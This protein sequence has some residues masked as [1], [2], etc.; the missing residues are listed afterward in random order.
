M[1]QRIVGFHQDDEGHW[2]AELECSH[3]QHLRHHP[4]WQNRPWVID[5]HQRQRFLGNKLDCKL[6]EQGEETQMATIRWIEDGVQADGVVEREFV[7]ERNGQIIPGVFWRPAD[8][9]SPQPLVLMGHGGSGHKRNDRMQMLGRLFSTGYGCCAA[10]IDGPV[11]GARGTVT[12]PNDPAFREM[13]RRDNPV[14]GMIDDWTA[15][16]DVLSQLEIVDHTRIG[17]WGVSMGTM[18][19]L[20]YVASDERVRV[21]VLGKAGTTGSS[22]RRSGI[23]TYFKTYA[24][25]VKVP[26]LFTIQ[27]DD[28]RFD[29]DGQLDLFDQ[30]GSQDKRLH[31]YPGL[32]IANGPEAFE[33]QAAF[34]KRYL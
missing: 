23:D 18:F 31:A 19:G 5:P 25:Q 12:D 9:S 22:V 32:H 24:P 1:Q 13:W 7:V 8:L 30:L 28:E 34:L 16:L 11:H 20:P 4:P 33:V 2:V 6:C 14:Q 29:R 17:Y 10:A 3:T 15:T 21:A 27:W 26:V